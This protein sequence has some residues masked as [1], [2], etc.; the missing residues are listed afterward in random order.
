MAVAE[1]TM[2]AAWWHCVKLHSLHSLQIHRQSHNMCCNGILS[3]ILCLIQNWW[4]SLLAQFGS[5]CGPKKVDQACLYLLIWDS[6]NVCVVGFFLAKEELFKFQKNIM[7]GLS[8]N[9]IKQ[10]RLKDTLYWTPLFS[11]EKLHTH[12]YD[13]PLDRVV[14]WWEQHVFRFLIRAIVRSDA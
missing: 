11:N 5:T 1:V 10:L 2:A 9:Y 12:E 14:H 6:Q 8:L 13:I 7:L 3:I 4:Q